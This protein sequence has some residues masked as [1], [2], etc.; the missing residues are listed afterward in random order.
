MTLPS[1]STQGDC[2]AKRLWLTGALAG[3][4]GGAAEVAWIVIY[5]HVLG[6]DAAAVAQGVTRSFFAGPSAA[7]LAVPLGVAIHMSLAIAIGVAI[8]VLLSRLCPRV[9][10]RAFE[11]IVVVGLLV[12]IW[13]VNFFLVLPA[14][15]PAFVDLVPYEASLTSKVL[16]GVAAAVVLQVRSQS[17]PAIEQA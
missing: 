7:A 6:A 17:I 16:F 5:G 10:R 3:L 12:A 4:A 11:P 14:I 1:R 9:C 13:T 15:N 8:A 2:R